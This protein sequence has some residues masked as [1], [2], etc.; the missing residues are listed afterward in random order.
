MGANGFQPRWRSDKPLYRLLF[1]FFFFLFFFLSSSS[2][3]PPSILL[4]V[5]DVRFMH[6]DV[7]MLARKLNSAVETVQTATHVALSRYKQV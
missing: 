4:V 1:S 5:F 6:A 3:F 2:S 7:A